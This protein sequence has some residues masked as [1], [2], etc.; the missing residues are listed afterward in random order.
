MPSHSRRKPIQWGGLVVG[1]AIIVS[2]VSVGGWFVAR[3]IF[4][5]QWTL[6][7]ADVMSSKP[8]A[9]DPTTDVVEVTSDACDDDVR[10]VEAYDTAEATYYRFASRGDAEEF[11]STVD[12]G[13]RSNYIVMDFAGKDAASKEQQ[14]WAMQ[15]LAGIWQ[16][17]EGEFP[18]R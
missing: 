17:Y 3:G 14:L 2:A 9:V 4:D 8:D 15:H 12:D 7:L 13:F 6:T 16:D 1:I 11:A 5:S 18:S 10:C